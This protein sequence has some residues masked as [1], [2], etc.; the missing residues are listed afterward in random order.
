MQEAYIHS[1][2]IVHRLHSVVKVI[3]TLALILFLNLTSNQAW[4]AYILY[5]TI[6]LSLV[7]LSRINIW[8]VIKRSLLALPFIL[9]AVPMIFTRSPMM[10][11]LQISPGINIFYSPEGLG[12]FLSILLKSWI[13]VQAAVLLTATTRFN[14]LLAAFQELRIP[15]IFIAITGLMW[16]YLFLMR[17][18]AIRM[19][20]AR[21]SRSSIS[22]HSHRINGNLFWRIKTTGGMAGSLFLR[23]IERSD[24]VYT[25]MLSRG[26]NGEMIAN[27]TSRPAKFEKAILLASVLFFSL[28]WVLGLITGG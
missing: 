27:D 4:S 26:Y 2:S 1:E 18:E 11:G 16:R 22:N 13:S 14:D 23:S 5:L 10:A 24:R 6:V 9:A 3:F 19:N 21:A 15:K 20:Q 8:T 17:D 12:K 28:L 7:I 25:A